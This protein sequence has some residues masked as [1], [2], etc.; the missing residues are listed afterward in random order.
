MRRILPLS[1]L[2]LFAGAPLAPT[3]QAEDKSLAAKMRSALVVIHTTSQSYNT[4]SP[5]KR[6]RQSTRTGRGV[7]VQ[8]G[9]IL[10]PASNVTYQQMIE[11]SIV[12]SARRYPAKLRHVDH[13]IGLALVEITDPELKKS[14]QPL[15]LG[16]PVKLDDELEIHQLGRDNMLERFTGRV[17]RATAWSTQLSLTLKTNCSDRGNGQPAVKDGK[18]VGLVT[19]TWSSRQEGTIL[20][21]ETIRHYL[22]DFNDDGYDGC[23]GSTPFTQQL[24][25][26]DLR[27]Y[28]GLSDDQHGV[29]ITRVPEDRTGAGVL[30]AGDVLLEADGYDIDDEGMFKHQTHGRLGMR[31]LF[32]GRRY[33]GD[34]IP[35]KVLREGK[36]VALEV[37]LLGQPKGKKQI[38]TGV[39]ETRPQF[40]V[41]GGLVLL[42]LTSRSP[43]GRSSG[44]VLLRR[45][46]ERAGWEKSDARP[47]IIYV[48]RV[49]PDESNKGLDTIRHQAVKT[50]NGKTIG[51]LEDVVEALKAP[52]GKHH[53]FRF[54]G[55][56]SDYV[57]PVDQL[58]AINKRIAETYRISKTRYIR[59]LDKE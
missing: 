55:V 45:Y 25:R 12:N 23:P 34:K 24:L 40:L 17:V 51:G 54:E 28:Y 41:T 43:I 37:T 11:F 7:V 3:A 10:T 5:W 20:S 48:D 18:V 15:P 21:L 30:K 58:E 6:G 50:V 35:V 29:A 46:R 56:T 14:M 27:T 4:T 49:M 42:D 9:V 53:V 26:A 44:G 1:V 36:E 39:I 13:R 16:D 38:P 19:S 52:A 2:L 31:Y 33:V 47:R 8:P 57:V 59:S 32:S 22:D